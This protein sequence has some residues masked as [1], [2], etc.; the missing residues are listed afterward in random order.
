M[1]KKKVVKSKEVVKE[2][3]KLPAIF[4]YDMSTI[5]FN[6][7]E[8]FEGADKRTI[9]SITNACEKSFGDKNTVIYFDSSYVHRILRTKDYIA[10]EEIFNLDDDE[11]INWE[12]KT[13][14]SLGAVM[15]LVN[16]KLSSIGTGKT[17][18][19]LTFVEQYLISMRDN[20]KFI[21]MRTKLEKDWQDEVNKL[22][23]QRKRKY[24]IEY[25]E[26]TGEPLKKNCQFSHIRSK[27]MYKNVSLD[28]NNGLIV[29][30]E[31]HNIIT[32][33]KVTNEDELLSLCKDKGW[34]TSWYNEYIVIMR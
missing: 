19:Y 12:N 1:P 7:P 30:A 29:N 31:T 16:K 22:K 9:K 5:S 4:Q 11:K 27:A 13:Y 20:D 10:R 21:N 23:N 2:G 17:R 14:V 8:A 25:D 24:K 33:K 6:K 18:D 26:L 32:A 34:E 28:I 15:K 3:E